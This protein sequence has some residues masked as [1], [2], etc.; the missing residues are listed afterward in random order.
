MD[1]NDLKNS[2]LNALK[3]GDK[4]RL[5][6]LRFL[7]SQVR[8]DVIAKYQADWETKT[9]KEDI[10]DVIRK[11]VKSH[12]ESKDAFAKANRMDL[13]DKEQAQLII[14]ESFLPP[15]LTDEEITS[16]VNDVVKSGETNFGL[17]MK[18]VLSKIKGQADGGKVAQ[19]VKSQLPSG[20]KS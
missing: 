17:V 3:A 2:I 16:I 5:E 20:I 1:L 13:A 18:A 7:L 9:T 12:R 4:V 8:Y 19:I 11:Q 14:L 10:L 15:V 6:T